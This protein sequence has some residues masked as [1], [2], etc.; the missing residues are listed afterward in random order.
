MSIPDAVALAE[1]RIK[2]GRDAVAQK[3]IDNTR[4]QS[5]LRRLGFA[6]KY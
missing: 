4:K 2:V 5:L 6:L 3:V 1:Q